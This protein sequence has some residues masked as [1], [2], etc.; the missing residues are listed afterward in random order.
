MQYLQQMEIGSFSWNRHG[1]W[2]GKNPTLQNHPNSWL[3][4]GGK[5]RMQS[6]QLF[7]KNVQGVQII[8]FASY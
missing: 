7:L 3:E 6:K 5:E 1:E 8:P 2:A 4:E